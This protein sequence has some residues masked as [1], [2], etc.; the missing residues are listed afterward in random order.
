MANMKY[1]SD[2]RG[3]TVELT[4][5][6][7]MDNKEFAEKFPGVKGLRYDGYQMRV[8]KTADSLLLMPMTRA[9]EYKAFPS[10]H[11]CNA[12]CLNGK[13]NGKCEC[14]CGGKNHGR[15]SVN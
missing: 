7:G 2:F 11:E 5:M 1:F 3:E 14:R 12:K 10:K 13:C 8:G 15:G 6:R 4:S 9:I